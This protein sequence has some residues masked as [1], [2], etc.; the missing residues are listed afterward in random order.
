MKKNIILCLLL[1]FLCVLT[2]CVQRPEAREIA[3]ERVSVCKA[4]TYYPTIRDK[5]DE[6]REI[7]F[8][9]MYQGVCYVPVRAFAREFEK[10]QVIW[11]EEDKSLEIVKPNPSDRT[12]LDAHPPKEMPRN[13]SVSYG[14]ISISLDGEPVTFDPAALPLRYDNLVYAPVEP[15]AEA[16]GM[17]C[18]WEDLTVE[19]PEG[20]YALKYLLIY[21]SNMAEKKQLDFIEEYNKNFH[22]YIYGFV[23]VYKYKGKDLTI[24][25]PGISKI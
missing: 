15:L 4:D 6:T 23:T 10:R 3:I 13:V 14:G 7:R 2:S 17:K 16:F 25:F 11:D 24:H 5:D 12:V 8:P 1:T 22:D 19:S 21:D 18:S 9:L 20:N